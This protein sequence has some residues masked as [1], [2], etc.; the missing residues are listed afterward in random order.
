MKKVKAIFFQGEYVPI[1][2]MKN[3]F[4]FLLLLFYFIFKNDKL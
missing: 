2:A 3:V 1:E 4:C